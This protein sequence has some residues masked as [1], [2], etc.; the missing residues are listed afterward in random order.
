MLSGKLTTN[1]SVEH[2][3]LSWYLRNTKLF[4][5]IKN[6]IPILLSHV[7]A[8]LSLL[9]VPYAFQESAPSSLLMSLIAGPDKSPP[10]PICSIKPTPPQGLVQKLYARFGNNNF[11][12]H[13]HLNTIGHGIFPQTSRLFNHSCLPNSAPKYILEPGRGYSDGSR[14]PSGYT[15]RRRG[16]IFS[17]HLYQSFSF[18]SAT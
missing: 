14:S 9:P 18:I 2:T 8:Q 6:W 4:R 7:I 11:A 15:G 3:I 10:P 1:E 12:I 13:S 5:T 16:E 17:P